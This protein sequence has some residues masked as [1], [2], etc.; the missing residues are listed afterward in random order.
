MRIYK[1]DLTQ[2]NDKLKKAAT[3]AT[4]KKF[5]DSVAKQEEKVARY[6]S[7]ISAY[8]EDY[9]NSKKGDEDQVTNAKALVDEINK[10]KEDGKLYTLTDDIR[11]VNEANYSYYSETVKLKKDETKYTFTVTADGQMV[12]NKKNESK[13]EVKLRTVGG[14]KLDFSTGIFANFGKSE[15]LGKDYFFKPVNDTMSQISAL[16]D[17][18]K[19]LLGIGG[20]MHIYFRSPSN[21]KA[22]LSIGASTTTGFDVVN[23]HVGPTLILGDQERFCLTAGLTLKESKILSDDYKEGILY[24]KSLLPANIE[25]VKKFPTTGFFFSLTYNL[26]RFGK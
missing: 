11:K 24:K 13:F 15:F 2:L 7:E 26:S 3:I 17:S 10:F 14:I 19:V 6:D 8:K 21:I 9:S 1:R 16:H 20:L 25:L 23:F 5:E 4:K 12:C 22:G 18:R